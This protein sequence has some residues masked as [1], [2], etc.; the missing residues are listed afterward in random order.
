MKR[1]DWQGMLQIGLRDLRL[2]PFE[3]WALTPTEF[4]LM[5]GLQAHDL[6]MTRGRLAGLE[7][8][9]TNKMRHVDGDI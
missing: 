5:A 4:A 6:P 8:E 1:L 7:A 2:K 9:L 3:F